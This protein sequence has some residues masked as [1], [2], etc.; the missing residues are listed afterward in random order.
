MQLILNLLTQ[1]DHSKKGANLFYMVS[2][3]LP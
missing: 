2:L 1:E 3:I